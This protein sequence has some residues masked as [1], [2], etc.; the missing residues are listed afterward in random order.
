MNLS[1]ELFAVVF[2]L[3]LTYPYIVTMKGWQPY[4]PVYCW[5]K[6]NKE[7]HIIVNG[8]YEPV[9]FIIKSFIRSRSLIPYGLENY[10]KNQ[11]DYSLFR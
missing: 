4:L 1:I 2:F 7:L 6:E 11:F 3:E 5:Q 8:A 9:H 10:K